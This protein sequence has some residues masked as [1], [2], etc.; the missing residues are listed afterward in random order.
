MIGEAAEACGGVAAVD[1]VLDAEEVAPAHGHHS[2]LGFKLLLLLGWRFETLQA[3]FPREVVQVVTHLVL[4]GAGSVDVASAFY[5]ELLD[6][7][8]LCLLQYLIVLPELFLVLLLRITDY[9]ELPIFNDVHV[10]AG[11]ALM[12]DENVPL[13]G[14]DMHILYQVLLRLQ[15]QSLENRQGVEEL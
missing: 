15:H 2:Y 4:L 13:I 6:P 11:L 8:V 9:L 3:L 12:E 10:G 7:P 1:G 14:L 5:H